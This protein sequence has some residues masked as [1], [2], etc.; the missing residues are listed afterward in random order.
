VAAPKPRQR[1][2]A[3]SVHSPPVETV[4]TDPLRVSPCAYWPH[5]LWTDGTTR[6]PLAHHFGNPRQ[7]RVLVIRHSGAHTSHS[8]G[9]GS[10][11]AGQKPHCNRDIAEQ[12]R[13]QKPLSPFSTE[14]YRYAA[15]VFHRSPRFQQVCIYLCTTQHFF[16]QSNVLCPQK[17][18]SH[19]APIKPKYC[20]F[21][22][23][24]PLTPVEKPPPP[25]YNGA[26]VPTRVLLLNQ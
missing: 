21:R 23:S 2:P 8:P 18:N 26:G 24:P 1:S 4:E 10:A 12:P 16:L 11:T 5:S 3:A 20:T 14:K 6:T 15:F 9:Q 13:H 7:L 17:A 22:T 19:R 25:G